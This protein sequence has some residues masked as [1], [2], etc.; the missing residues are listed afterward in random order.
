MNKAKSTK[1]F[2]IWEVQAQGSV[3]VRWPST[4]RPKGKHFHRTGT[5]GL[6]AF[7]SPGQAASGPLAMQPQLLMWQGRSERCFEGI[8]IHRPISNQNKEQL[9]NHNHYNHQTFSSARDSGGWRG[10]VAKGSS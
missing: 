4:V 9:Y 3:V 6:K 5:H 10:V 2:F 7:P 1:C 8:Y